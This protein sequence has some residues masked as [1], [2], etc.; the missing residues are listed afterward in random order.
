[1]R[2]LHKLLETPKD[3]LEVL[4]NKNIT[5]KKGEELIETVKEICGEYAG[6]VFPYIYR[7]SLSNTQSRRSRAGKSFEAIIYKIYENLGYE[8]DSQSKVGRKTFDTLGL[9][10]KV[11]SI[12]PN[13]KCY[14]ERR[15]KTIIGTM[16]T[17]LRERWQEVAEEIER[18]KIPEIHLLTAD[19]SIP[20]SKAQEM[21]NHNII[22]V[23]Y[24]WVANSVALK[25]MKNIISFEE[26]LFEEIPNILKFWNENK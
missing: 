14:A 5:D 19:E 16:K 7:L 26:Y 3:I 9:G 6:R 23:T 4:L 13:I 24:E 12:L 21:A 2:D 18:T 11:D 1:M 8:Y 25:S 17:S 10:K 15:N 22:V 20:K